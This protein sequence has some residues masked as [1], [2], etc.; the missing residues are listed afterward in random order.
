M[1]QWIKFISFL[2]CVGF[3]VLIFKGVLI[4]AD[5]DEP[6][7]LPIVLATMGVFSLGITSIIY[8]LAWGNNPTRMYQSASTAYCPDCFHNS[9]DI[10]AKGLFTVKH[11]W[12]VRLIGSSGRCGNCGS[13]VKT[14]WFFFVIPLIPV[15][16]FR[17]L[18][19]GEASL[20]E[21]RLYT[22]KLPT[23]DWVQVSARYIILAVIAGVVALIVKM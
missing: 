19:A 10:P 12:G 8:Y 2:F 17:V 23:M 20:L 9:Q 3:V 16:S 7:V 21:A 22:R 6:K 14:R 11:I 18:R 4:A 13:I 5:Y 1:P 15:G